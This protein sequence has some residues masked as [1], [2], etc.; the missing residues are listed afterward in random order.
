ML[1]RLHV[2]AVLLD[3]R[4]S[5]GRHHWGKAKILTSRLLHV[6]FVVAVA[7]IAVAVEK[8]ITFSKENTT[9]TVM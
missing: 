8:Q 4:G 1:V 5:A 9:F 7:V 2:S 6:P 3:P